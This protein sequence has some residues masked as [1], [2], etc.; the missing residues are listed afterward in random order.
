MR[1]FIIPTSV[2]SKGDPELEQ[3]D[4]RRYQVRVNTVLGM[5]ELVDRVMWSVITRYTTKILWLLSRTCKIRY[6]VNTL[7]TG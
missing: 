1:F 5:S 4:R 2:P 6:Q 3:S 7:K